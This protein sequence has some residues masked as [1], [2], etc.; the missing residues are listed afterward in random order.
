MIVRNR[1]GRNPRVLC[2][3]VGC[4]NAEPLHVSSGANSYQ[5]KTNPHLGAWRSL[6]TFAQAQLHFCTEHAAVLLDVVL[7]HVQIAAGASEQ[8]RAVAVVTPFF[9]DERI[10]RPEHRPADLGEG[11]R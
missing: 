1:A 4:G 5:V 11:S 2:D 6:G 3:V 7:A 9:V 8:L 10:E